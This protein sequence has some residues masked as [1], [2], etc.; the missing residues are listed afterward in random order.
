MIGGAFVV[1]SNFI[2]LP[3]AIKAYKWGHGIW[4]LFFLSV[5]LWSSSYHIC[6][7]FKGYCLFGNYPLL[8]FLDF[9]SAQMDVTVSLLQL[10]YWESP[11]TMIAHPVSVPFLQTAF[12][13]FFGLL[14]AVLVHLTGA[15]PISQFISI[16]AVGLVIICYW[17]DYY[18]T[19]RSFPRYNYSHMILGLS[20]MGVS[21]LLFNFQNIVPS[22][23]FYIHSLWHATG[24][25][26]GWYWISVTVKYPKYLNMG[27]AI[28]MQVYEK[29]HYA[30]QMRKLTRIHNMD[31]L[32]TDVDAKKRPRS[33]NLDLSAFPA[34]GN[35]DLSV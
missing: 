3:V 32:N 22:L 2:A 14:N 7:T 1:V 23:Y 9:W 21:I 13:F 33:V 20:F 26:G 8:H 6:D 5:L 34:S 28:P 29:P 30:Q 24:L 35:S 31:Y 11:T 16:A 17:I 25:C 27:D 15:S 18:A 4:P 10:I 19:Y 12:F